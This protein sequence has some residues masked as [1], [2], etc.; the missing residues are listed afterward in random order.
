MGRLNVQLID[1]GTGNH[2]WAERFDKPVADLFDIQDEIVSRLANALDAELVAAEAR[3]AERTLHPDCMDLVFQGRAWLNKGLTPE[4]LT[5]ARRF[6]ERGS[7]FKKVKNSCFGRIAGLAPGS[8]IFRYGCDR[9][10]NRLKK[11]ARPIHS[12]VKKG[13]PSPFW[14]GRW[15]F[16]KP[17]HAL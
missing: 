10:F 2:L 17:W 4:N 6:F 5:Q 8:R 1:A 12:K 11:T 3:R 13:H 14:L 15:Q 9:Y 7:L 16:W